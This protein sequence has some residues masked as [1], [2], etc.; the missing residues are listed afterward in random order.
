MT[1]SEACSECIANEDFVR[2]WNRLTGHKLGVSRSPLEAA[3]DKACGYNP[4]EKAM[5]DFVEF[6]HECIW[7]PLINQYIAWENANA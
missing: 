1:F 6:V 4:D 3:I 2:E 7:L 5:P